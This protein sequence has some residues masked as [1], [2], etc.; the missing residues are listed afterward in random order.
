MAS[1]SSSPKEEDPIKIPHTVV[2]LYNMAKAQNKEA[3]MSKVHSILDGNEHEREKLM[4]MLE[5]LIS[6]N[7]QNLTTRVL[8]VSDDE[9]LYGGCRHAQKRQPKIQRIP[10][11]KRKIIKA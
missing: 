2:E 3:F 4:G 9:F 6:M 5:K 1:S 8:V 10:K 11:K 7:M